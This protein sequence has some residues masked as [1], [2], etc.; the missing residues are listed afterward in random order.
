MLWHDDMEDPESDLKALR[1][2]IE[3]E[4]GLY[5]HLEQCQEYM[6]AELEYGYPPPGGPWHAR[7]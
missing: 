6:A 7:A 4:T 5:P 2:K 3:E 1:E